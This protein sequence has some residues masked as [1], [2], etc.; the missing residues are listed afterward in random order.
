MAVGQYGSR[1]AFFSQ[2]EQASAAVLLISVFLWD[3]FQ[4]SPKANKNAGRGS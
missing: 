2:R 4:D 3:K 1:D